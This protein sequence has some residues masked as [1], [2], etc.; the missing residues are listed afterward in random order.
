[1]TVLRYIFYFFSADIVY[2]AV[3]LKSSFLGC[4]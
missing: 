4:F 2:E 1:M 3:R